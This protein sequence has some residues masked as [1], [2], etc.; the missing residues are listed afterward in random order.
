M[1][2]TEFRAFA[3]SPEF[4]VWARKKRET[5]ERA[6]VEFLWPD[7]TWRSERPPPGTNLHYRKRAT[8]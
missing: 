8:Q 5:W 1:S 7:N 2:N 6:N 4:H 3:E